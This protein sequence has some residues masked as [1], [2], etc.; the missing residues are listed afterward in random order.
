MGQKGGER[1]ALSRM[2]RRSGQRSPCVAGIPPAAVIAWDE[3]WTCQK[4]G[5]QGKRPEL[6]VWTAVVEE[7]DGR[8]WADFEVGSRGAETLLRLYARLPEAKLYC[9]DGLRVCLEWLPAGRHVVG[10][11]GA[12]NWNEGLHSECRTRLNR[13]RR[14]TKGCRESR[15]LLERLLALALGRW[16]AKPNASLC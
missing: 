10:K 4:A 15:D 9:S 11:G 16:T 1:A 7:T 13:L 3:M 8:R 12:V 14:R 6:W 5:C 2:G